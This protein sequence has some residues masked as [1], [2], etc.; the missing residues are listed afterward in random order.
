MFKRNDWIFGLISICVGVFVLI[1]IRSL[2]SLSST[3]DQAGP[4]ALPKIISWIMIG[5]GIVHVIF[6]LQ[7]MMRKNENNTSDKNNSATIKPVILIVIASAAFILSLT[8]LG[9]LIT[10]PLLILAIMLSVG[11]RDVKKIALTSIVTTTVLFAAFYYGLN[12]DL[13]L[14]IL[15]KFF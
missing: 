2:D 14:G 15:E 7:M 4:A 3:M 12:V 5:I 10:L 6:P 11:V 1:N 8:T 9:Y 13:P